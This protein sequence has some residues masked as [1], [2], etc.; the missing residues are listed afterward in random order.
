[1]RPSFL[2][3]QPIDYIRPVVCVIPR[4]D[5]EIRGG[6]LFHGQ[7]RFKRP[8]WHRSMWRPRLSFASSMNRRLPVSW[9]RWN[10]SR[11]RCVRAPGCPAQRSGVANDSLGL[12]AHQ[13]EIGRAEL[14]P[15]TARPCAGSSWT[16]DTSLQAPPF[17]L[18][19]PGS[20]QCRVQ[21]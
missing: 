19:A 17:L 14:D 12:V 1:M 16:K 11:I 3:E 2:F 10:T 9:P 15:T 4:N 6:L 21:A 18:H 13:V 7:G 8:G 20:I 5:R